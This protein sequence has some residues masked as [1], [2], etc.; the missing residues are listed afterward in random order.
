MTKIKQLLILK[1]AVIA[2][3]FF[4][5]VLAGFLIF[6]WN[7]EVPLPFDDY[8]MSVEVHPAAIVTDEEG[9]I[10]WKLIG[11]DTDGIP[12]NYD[13]MINVVIIAHRGMLRITQSMVGRDISRDEED[14]RVVYYCHCKTLWNSLFFD[15][16]L[17]DY[18]EIGWATGSPIYGENY[19]SPDYEPKM[20][21]IY[22]L[23]IRNLYQLQKLPEDKFDSLREKATLVWS[24]TV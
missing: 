6:A 13:K 7:Y 20:I 1:K 2:A 23:P 12:E 14:V 4:I 21:E 5:D 10:S 8:R 15:G 24:G 9:G 19:L 16:D 17:V 22:Y 11:T 3:L 18:S